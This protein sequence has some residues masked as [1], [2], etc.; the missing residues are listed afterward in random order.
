[1][2]TPVYNFV[3]GYNDKHTVRAHMPGHKGKSPIITEIS[4]AYAYDI[5]EISGADA[6]FEADGIIAKS[7]KRTAELYGVNRTLFSAGGSTLCIQAM[8]AI[9]CKCGNTVVAARNA[10]RSF[11]NTCALLGLDPVWVYPEYENGSV[12][13]GKISPQSIED[14][15]K[16]GLKE[17]GH[18]SAV[19]ITSP[20]Y[21]G[22]IADVKGIS[23]ICRKYDIPLLV[24]NAHGAHLAFLKENLHP[25]VMGA[26]LCCDSAHKSLPV[27]TGGAYLHIINPKY[28]D[29]AKDCMAMFGSSSPSYLI[30]QSLD[31]CAEYLA[32]N[33]RK[34]LD[35]TVKRID[36]LKKHISSVYTVCDSEP[37][38]ISIYTLPN[39]LYGYK[40]ADIL[41]QS[42]IECEYADS[43]HVV[44]MFSTCTT[45]EDFEAVEKALMA[46]EMQKIK[47]MPPEM[48]FP[49]LTKA[50][51]VRE[52][53]FGESES[54]PVEESVGRICA[55][56][57]TV[58]PPC[59][60]VAVCGE[61]ISKDCIKILKNYSISYINVLK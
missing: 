54:I 38:R 25:S 14:G 15:I 42:N 8:L 13:S 27:L 46:V 12:V 17:S 7:E 34:E 3:K 22:K 16:R 56:T 32:T 43:T 20:D 58:C 59:I 31:L 48:N 18:V 6:L 11:I 4:S 35:D 29:K 47:L 36:T 39:G 30:M 10:H 2:N 5:T 44:M 53:A 51:S 37:L 60:P 61:I 49:A 40:L 45:V 33:F 1:M 55:K 19:Y 57:A 28:A 50:C 41:R 24:D 9:T 21:L 26:D 23:E 52:A